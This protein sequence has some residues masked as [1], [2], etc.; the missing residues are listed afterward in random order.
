MRDGTVAH[1]FNW[2]IASEAFDV[3]V[4]NLHR[5]N[6]LYVGGKVKNP[7]KNIPYSII[8]SVISVSVGYLLCNLGYFVVLPASHLKND[9]GMAV[10]FGMLTLGKIGQLIIPLFIIAR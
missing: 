5:N 6:L 8:I 1:L 3:P 2:K 7:Q 4:L 9:Q 10:E